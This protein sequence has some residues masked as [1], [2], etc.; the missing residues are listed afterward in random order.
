MYASKIT[1]KFSFLVTQIRVFFFLDIFVIAY[2]NLTGN[3]V[4]FKT[5]SKGLQI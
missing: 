2:V 5:L 1:V 3:A 4:I